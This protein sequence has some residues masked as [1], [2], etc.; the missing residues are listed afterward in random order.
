MSTPKTTIQYANPIY[1]E[2]EIEAVVEALRTT[3]Q[4]QIGPRVRE[5]ERRVAALFDK[6]YGIMTNS[7]T[8]ALYLAVELLDLP[9]GSEI[10]TSVVSFSATFAPIVRAGLVASYVDVEYDTYNIDVDQI[11][12]MITPRTRAILVPNLIG[13]APDWERIREIADRH[14]LKVIEDSADTLGAK[15]RGRTTGAWT[16]ISMTSFAA[17]HII[18][19]GGSGGMLAVNS[20]E[21][22]DRAL[23]LRRWG[24]SSE[25]QMFGSKEHANE[26]FEVE[27]DGIP[28]DTMFIFDE[29]GWNFEPSEMH[30]AFG[31]VQLGKLPQFFEARKRRFEMHTEFFNRDRILERFIPARQLEDLETSWISYPLMVRE[32]AG[33]SRQQLQRFLEDKGIAT[34]M[35]W[36]GNILRQPAFK[37][38][39]HKAAP[40]G[41]PNA[42]R[43]MRQGII[44]PMSHAAPLDDI[45]LIHKAIEKFVSSHETRPGENALAD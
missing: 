34:R 27:I 6:K 11:E 44:L 2:E 22:L 24:R 25:V 17:S 42:D 36:S 3:D 31:L 4:I 41:Y 5:M 8:S 12:E 35:I 26:R 1:G 38:T 32:E 9:K 37:N 7:G 39:P 10:I 18:T 28:Y 30:A 21:E 19:S 20:E 16:D 14:D 29:V 23:L 15:L 33:F 43:V 40:G 13:N 45:E